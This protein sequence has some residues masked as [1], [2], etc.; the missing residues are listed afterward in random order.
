MAFFLGLV[1]VLV[2][3]FSVALACYISFFKTEIR[4]TFRKLVLSGFLSVCL[5]LVTSMLALLVLW[6][7]M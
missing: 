2:V 4:S 6:P 3:V 5:F 1:T 7:P